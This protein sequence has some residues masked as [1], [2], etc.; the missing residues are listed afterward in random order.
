MIFPRP[1]REDWCLGSF[2]FYFS[3]L[4]VKES[5]FFA[6]ATKNNGIRVPIDGGIGFIDLIRYV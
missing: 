1:Q 5:Y 4:W 2:T 6:K 3:G